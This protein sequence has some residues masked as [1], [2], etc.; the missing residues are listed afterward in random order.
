ML[1][2]SKQDDGWYCEFDS[3]VYPTMV[4]RYVM[5]TKVMDATGELNISFFNEQVRS[6]DHIMQ[7]AQGTKCVHPNKALEGTDALSGLAS[8][9]SSSTLWH[10]ERHQ[11]ALHVPGIL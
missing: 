9:L 1:Q 5:L 4:R 11:S 10:G 8:V 3:K 2:V 6:H 7:L